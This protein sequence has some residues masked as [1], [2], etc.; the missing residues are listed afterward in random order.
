MCFNFVIF[1]S[2]FYFLDSTYKWDQI[3]FVFLWLISL[4]IITS[5]FIHVVAHG[6]ISIIL[7][8]GI[9]L[10]YIYTYHIFFFHSSDGGHLGCFHIL[11]IIRVLVSF[12]IFFFLDKYPEVEFWG[13]MVVLFLVFW[14][15]FILYFHSGCT[16][17]TTSAWGFPFLHTLANAC[18]LWS[19]W[20]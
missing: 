19:F 1:T 2:L 5:K 4:S 15:I 10:L 12:Q 13:H 11:L 20:W 18:Y 17:F 9:I 7:L 8:V 6:K 14:G 16:I 3:V